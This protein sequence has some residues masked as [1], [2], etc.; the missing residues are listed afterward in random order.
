MILFVPKREGIQLLTTIDSLLDLVRR[1]LL[2]SA[3][4]TFKFLR[5]N[6]YWAKSKKSALKGRNVCANVFN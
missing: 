3:K 2:K 4:D 1:F 6:V 5:S